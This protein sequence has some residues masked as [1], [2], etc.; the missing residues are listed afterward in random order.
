MLAVVRA[1]TL[2]RLFLLRLGLR[3]RAPYHGGSVSKY[4]LRLPTTD[5]RDGQAENQTPS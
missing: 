3:G 1:R 4:A 5:M 2:L